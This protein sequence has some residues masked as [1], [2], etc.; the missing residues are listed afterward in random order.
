MSTPD[1]FVGID[2]GK[3][4]HYAYVMNT[5][6]EK[7]LSLTVPNTNHEMLQ[8]FIRAV[9]SR[10]QV[11]HQQVPTQA[12]TAGYVLTNWFEKSVHPT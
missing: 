12:K 2:V 9:K 1:I 10:Y 7:S 4:T 3:T 6:G 5:D 8:I 11:R